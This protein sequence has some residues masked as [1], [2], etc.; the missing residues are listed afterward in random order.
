[1]KSAT[2]NELDNQILGDISGGSRVFDNTFQG[3]AGNDLLYGGGGSDTLVGGEGSDR[4]LFGF[5]PGNEIIDARASQFLGTDTIPDFVRGI[6][7]IVLTTSFAAITTSVGQ[8]S[9]YFAA[10]ADDAQVEISSAV[11]V[12]SRA[13]QKVFYNQNAI[14]AGLGEGSAIAIL[15]GVS[16]LSSSDIEIVANNFLTI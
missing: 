8:P 10:V 12:F 3:L 14:A 1:L 15:P 6:D 11:I 16:D 5:N 13:T 9:A 4:F 2:G 7:K